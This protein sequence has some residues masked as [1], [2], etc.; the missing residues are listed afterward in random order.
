[1]LVRRVRR[2]VA[3]RRRHLD[4]QQPVCGELGRDDVGDLAG[5]V[6]RPAH[7]DPHRRAGSIGCTGPAGAV[8]ACR[9]AGHQPSPST[10]HVV[11]GGRYSASGSASNG[12]SRAPRS[13]RSPPAVAESRPPR[14]TRQTSSAP[15]SSAA[16]AR[17]RGRSCRTAISIRPHR[18]SPAGR[19][20]AAA[21][22]ASRQ[23]SLGWH[24]DRAAQAR[25]HV[26]A[27]PV[28]HGGSRRRRVAAQQ[29]PAEGGGEGVAGAEAVH[30]LDRVGPAPPPAPARRRTPSRRGRRACWRRRHAQIEQPGGAAV[31]TAAAISSSEPSATSAWRAASRMQAA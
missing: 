2:P 17:D 18:A 12:V 6:A 21:G 23:V 27:G 31:P 30:D 24:C 1:M 16:D 5:G 26:R 9:A 20:F 8:G 3:G 25:G 19:A 7:L 11:P 29:T 14:L 22:R 4:H 13:K 10:V 28:G 15:V